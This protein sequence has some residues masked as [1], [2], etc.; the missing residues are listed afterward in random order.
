MMMIDAGAAGPAAHVDQ[1]QH[2]GQQPLQ[3]RQHR[4]QHSCAVA[5][6]AP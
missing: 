3:R 6:W 4:Q 1:P 5:R 2:R